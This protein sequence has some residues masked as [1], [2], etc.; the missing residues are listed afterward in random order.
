M[1]IAFYKARYGQFFDKVIALF[2]FSK[3][4]H[5]EI[6]FEDGMCAS[7]SVRDG[8][9]RFK[10][11]VMGVRWDVYDL[12]VGI[13]EATVRQWFV[14]NDHQ[15]YDLWG[16]IGSAFGLNLS[17]DDKK[18]CSESCA[19]VLGLDNTVISPGALY[20]LLTKKFYIHR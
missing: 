3:Y 2:T 13:D 6:V 4:S 5:C 18:F 8:G 11:I 16:A 1:K 19:T 14:D 9:V 10:E 12:M 20:E 17:N 15:E 7:A